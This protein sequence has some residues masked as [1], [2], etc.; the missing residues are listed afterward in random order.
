MGSSRI[1]LANF[2][3]KACL[4]PSRCFHHTRSDVP[5]LFS[6]I[7]SHACVLGGVLMLSGGLLCLITP[8]CG[9]FSPDAALRG[10][11][12]RPCASRSGFTLLVFASLTGLAETNKH[13]TPTLRPPFPSHIHTHTHTIKKNHSCSSAKAHKSF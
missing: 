5:S 13:H 2:N 9:C 6:W 1:E 4:H 11:W 10:R 12:S 3:Q 8:V 7:H